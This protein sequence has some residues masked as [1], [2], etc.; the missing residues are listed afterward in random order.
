MKTAIERWRDFFD[1]KS[2]IKKDDE[3]TIDLIVVRDPDAPTFAQVLGG[4]E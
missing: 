2:G 1:K 3:P 4:R